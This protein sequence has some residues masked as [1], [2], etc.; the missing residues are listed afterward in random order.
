MTFQEEC[1]SLAPLETFDPAA[2]QADLKTPQSLCNFVLALALIYNDCKDT[3]GAR[4]MLIQSKPEGEYRVNRIWGTYY[5]MDLH[6]LRLFI[7]LLHELFALIRDN[8][9]VL[10]HPLMIEV[11]RQLR[12]NAR[13]AWNELVN[14]ALDATPKSELGRALLLIRNKVLFHY[15]PKCLFIGHSHHFLGQDR[16][17]D[18]A[19]VSRGLSMSQSRFYFADAAV[20][21]YLHQTIGKDNWDDFIKNAA[22]LF[23]QLNV[24]LLSIVDRFIQKRGFAYRA[25]PE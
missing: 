9:E 8:R 15:D 24:S 20:Q 12:A 21:G 10:D 19:F 25:A 7:S 5:G 11:I 6:L 2:F 16:I 22:E 14:V 1:A 23:E 17:Q 4:V 13:A 3:I 18:R